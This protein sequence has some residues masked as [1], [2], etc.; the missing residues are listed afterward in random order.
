MPEARDE[1]NHSA[2]SEFVFLG[3]TNSWAVQLLLFIFSL[4]FYFSSM[5]GNLVIVFTVTFDA[6]L[7]SPMYFLLANLSVIDMAFCSITAPKMIC[8]IFKKHKTI[9]FWGCITQI[10]F[11]HA[12]GGTEMVLLIA[13]AFDR[14]MA[15]CKP[16]HYLTI[17]SPLRC[18][19]F[20]ITAWIIGLVHSVIQ[21]AFVVDLPLCGPNELDSFFL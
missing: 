21:L 17:M 4:L 3:L 1:M 11:S 16:L 20:L 8:D 12:V 5:M 9:S 18:I 10:F 7:Q 2:V 14:Y 19:L 15:I 13:M 6:H